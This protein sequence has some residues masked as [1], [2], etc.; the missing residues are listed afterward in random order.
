MISPKFL[1]ANGLDVKDSGIS[2]LEALFCGSR[3]GGAK[4]EYWVSLKPHP[5]GAEAPLFLS[6]GCG[7][8]EVVPFQSGFKLTQY[9]DP[10]RKSMGGF[11]IRQAAHDLFQHFFNPDI[12]IANSRK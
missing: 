5:S 11:G 1:T 12:R 2:G 3:P 4:S 7:T 6:G 8:T 10:G 9:R